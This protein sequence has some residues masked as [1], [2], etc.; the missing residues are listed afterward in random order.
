MSRSQEKN[1][2]Q[3]VN[4]KF[5]MVDPY[6]MGKKSDGLLDFFFIFW[7][8]GFFG[9]EIMIITFKNKLETFEDALSKREKF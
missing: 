5:F 4:E 2:G 1:V 7:R 6:W 9:Q 8:L 3:K